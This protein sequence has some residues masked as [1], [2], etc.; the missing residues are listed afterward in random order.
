MMSNKKRNEKFTNGGIDDEDNC[1]GKV[2]TVNVEVAAD[3]ATE[4]SNADVVGTSDEVEEPT[5]Q[6][7]QLHKNCDVEDVAFDQYLK[8]RAAAEVVED[9]TLAHCEQ[10]WV[11]RR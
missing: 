2:V 3:K 8:W 6:G 1:Q 9:W 11:P 7:S 10:S 4:Q 5:H